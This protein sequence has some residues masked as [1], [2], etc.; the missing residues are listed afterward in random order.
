VYQRIVDKIA[1]GALVHADETRARIIGKEVYVWVFTSLEEVAFVVSESREASTAHEFL[2][3]F[4]GVLVS[5]FYTGYD[6]IDCS[7]QRCIIHPIRDINDDLCKQPFNEE[8]KGIARGFANLLRPIIESV[9]WFGL[10]A[11]HLRKHRPAVDRF[12]KDLFNRKYE[13]DV[14]VGYRICC[15]TTSLAT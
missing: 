15:A 7:Q 6:S 8:M 11:R 10:K 2:A 1:R 3:D 13:T 5:G 9:D 12:Y 14:A 4:K